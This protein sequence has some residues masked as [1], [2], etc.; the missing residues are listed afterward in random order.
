MATCGT[1]TAAHALTTEARSQLAVQDAFVRSEAKRLLRESAAVRHLPPRE[2]CRVRWLFY[3]GDENYGLG[4][5]LY[6]VSSAA[7]LAL[8]LNRT[9]AYGIDESDRKFGTLLH[10]PGMLTLNEADELRRK[11]R[12]GAGA[13]AKRRHVQLAPDRCT[14]H[15]TW[16]KERAGSVRCFKRLLGVNWL[17]ERAPLLELSKVHA[18]SGLQT[19][20]KSAHEPLRRRVAAF[21]GGCLARGHE[22]PNVHGALLA[23]LMRPVPAVVHAVNWALQQQQQQQQQQRGVWQ[24][25]R[26]SGA[27]PP[28]IALHVRAMSDYRA[29]NTSAAEQAKQ[30]LNGLHCVRT[31]LAMAVRS[32]AV[33]GRRGG[34]AGGSLDGV[35]AG[36]GR[37]LSVVVV[38]SSPELRAHLVRRIA[39]RSRR[40]AAAAAATTASTATAT[41]STTTAARLASDPT[42]PSLHPFVFDWRQYVSSAPRAIVAALASSEAAADAF[43]RGVNKSDAFRCNRS[44]HLKDWGPE[45]HWVAVVELLLVASV[46][47][48]VVGAGSP[49]FKVC[50]TFTQVGAALADAAPDWLRN[51]PCTA[52]AAAS[53]GAGA[54][55]GAAT[56]A[57]NRAIAWAR[58][59]S[60]GEAS[61]QGGA[62]CGEGAPLGTPL[63]A[64]LGAPLGS[65]GGG[66]R[67]VRLLCA[68]RFVST[69]WGSSMW[70][71][72]NATRRRGSDYV[73]DC[74]S[75]SC[76]LTP[77]HPELWQGMQEQ[78]GVQDTGA[79]T[80]SAGGGFS[81]SRSTCDDVEHGG[82]GSVVFGQPIKTL[83]HSHH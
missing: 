40:A 78:L 35:A 2:L 6:D 62:S 4:N 53:A 67:G 38:S 39:S 66:P 15:R 32:A 46:S 8:V 80:M 42:L 49:Y 18:Y 30:M 63:G 43:C 34:D 37:P 65:S 9:L 5:V 47:H 33:D 21:T 72:L 19:L 1:S 14:F 69:D 75:P 68:S 27:S 24:T 82:D 58:A 13:L 36:L 20:L 52:A 71:T 29:R 23:T 61:L 26:G 16:R 81:S 45:P 10:W 70:R 59:A 41:T 3:R 76:L 7:A 56:A 25:G 60:R 17:A 55:A 73:V 11:A 51:L 28:A 22:R 74:G 77:L 48:V 57:A 83:T 12:C 54:A 44:A 64:P 79:P 50:N 31:A